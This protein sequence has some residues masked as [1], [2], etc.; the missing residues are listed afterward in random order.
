MTRVS[1]ACV[2]MVMGT[3][4]VSMGWFMDHVPLMRVEVFVKRPII[5]NAYATKMT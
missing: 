3:S 4:C 5:A 2:A 1:S